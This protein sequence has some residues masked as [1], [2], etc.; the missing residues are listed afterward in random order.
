[1]SPPSH[2]S[3]YLII[4]HSPI[5]P[6]H[7]ALWIPRAANPRTGKLIN[8]VGDPATGFVHEFQRNF[9][10]ERVSSGTISTILLSDHVEA[11]HIVDGEEAE[12]STIDAEAVDD[13]ERVA[14]GIP[15][16]VKSLNSV[17]QNVSR[18]VA[19]GDIYA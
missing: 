9:W 3:I 19:S 11:S 4:L 14:L 17:T 13:V 15:P 5:F 16:P 1:M 6:A 10:P 2:R 12:E 18:G 7:W 8:A